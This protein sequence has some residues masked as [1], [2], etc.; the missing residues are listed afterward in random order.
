MLLFKT[1]ARIKLEHPQLKV[2]KVCPA[3]HDTFLLVV[4]PE[5]T[6]DQELL[7]HIDNKGKTLW[8]N[9]YQDSLDTFGF[10]S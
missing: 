9:A 10:L 3:V 2:L 8:Q 7:L 4:V 6:Y 5:G 1:E